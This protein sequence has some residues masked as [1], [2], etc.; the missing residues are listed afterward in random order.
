MTQLKIKI[1]KIIAENGGYI[2]GGTI[3]ERIRVQSPEI[4]IS[5]INRAVRELFLDGCFNGNLETENL[6]LGQ[7]VG[8][9]E[10][11]ADQIKSFFKRK[12]TWRIIW[13]MLVGITG[14]IASIFSVLSYFKK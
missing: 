6:I 13:M 4:K 2:S 11:G 10:K 3:F 12:R 9:S 8:L 7:T 5:E 1:L 14:I